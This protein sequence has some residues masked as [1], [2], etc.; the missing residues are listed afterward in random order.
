MAPPGIP[1]TVSTPTFSSA[2]TRAWAP[3]ICSVI[4]S[5]LACWL[6]EAFLLV[7]AKGHKKCPVRRVGE[8]GARAGRSTSSA[9]CALTKY[10]EDPTAVHGNTLLGALLP[11]PTSPSLVSLFGRRV[12]R[13]G[14]TPRRDRPRPALGTGRG[15]TV[16]RC[17]AGPRAWCA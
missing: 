10:Y 5:F 3:V 1:N 17:S 11:M 15:G 14:G 16:R 8:T 2:L 6:R 13:S 9:A 4:G 12:R 7:R